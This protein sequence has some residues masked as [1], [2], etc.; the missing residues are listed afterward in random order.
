MVLNKTQ[1]ILKDKSLTEI[2]V[3][4]F[5]CFLILNRIKSTED[6]S[7]S[8]LNAVIKNLISSW[9]MINLMVWS[10]AAALIH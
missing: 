8:E 5:N 6:L 1:Y 10:V 3:S 2:V 4:T 9:V 7:W